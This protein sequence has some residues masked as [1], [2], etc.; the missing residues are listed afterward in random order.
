MIQNIDI[1]TIV[2]MIRALPKQYHTETIKIAT[3]KYRMPVTFKELFKKISN[4]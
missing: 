4:G 1:Q 2:T 3:G